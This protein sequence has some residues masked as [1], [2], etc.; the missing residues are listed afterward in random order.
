M[1]RKVL[2]RAVCGTFALALAT[3]LPAAERGTPAE[4]KAMLAKAVAHY[5]AVGREQALADFNAK[6]EPFGDRDL[7]VFCIGP[8]NVQVANGGYPSLVGRTADTVPDINGKPMGKAIWDAAKGS[9]SVRYKWYNPVSSVFERQ[10]AFAQT[11]G[12]EVCGVGAYNP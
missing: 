1:T 3:T 8:D 9:G 12:N 4:A 5:K 11:V 6:K 7:Y 10:V 2:I